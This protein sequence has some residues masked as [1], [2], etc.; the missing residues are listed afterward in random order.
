VTATTKVI[1]LS[2]FGR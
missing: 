2:W 1:R